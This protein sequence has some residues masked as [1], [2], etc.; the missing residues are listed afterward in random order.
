MNDTLNDRF[1]CHA[2]APE[3]TKA[4]VFVLVFVLVFAFVLAH[5]QAISDQ[6][7]DGTFLHSQ[8]VAQSVE[9]EL[10]AEL[11]SDPFLDELVPVEGREGLGRD[12]QFVPVG[13]QVVVFR[14]LREVKAVELKP[15]SHLFLPFEQGKRN[16]ETSGQNEE[17]KNEKEILRFVQE[18]PASSNVGQP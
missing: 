9:L 12:D 16:L 3:R 4:L 10:V 13:F 18:I 7:L 15:T 5:E 1:I 6:T 8:G 11:L 14:L 17:I 2:L